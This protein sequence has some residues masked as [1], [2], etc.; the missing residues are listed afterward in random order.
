MRDDGYTFGVEKTCPICEKIFLYRPD[1]TY[2]KVHYGKL[3][4]FCSWGCMRKWEKAHN[5]SSRQELRDRICQALQDGLTVKET[6]ALLDVDYNRVLYWR[7]KLKA[8]GMI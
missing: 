2:K 1:Y 5:I 7:K 8:E 4:F 6:A 3:L